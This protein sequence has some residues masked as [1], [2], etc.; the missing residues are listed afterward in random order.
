MGSVSSWLNHLRQTTGESSGEEPT[1][2][3]PRK[4]NVA[5]NWFEELKQKVPVD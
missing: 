1:A 5:L 3:G 4:I 2:A